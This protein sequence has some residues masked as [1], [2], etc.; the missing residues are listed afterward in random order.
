MPR[1]RVP[2]KVVRHSVTLD[3]QDHSEI[4]RLAAELDLSTAWI[5]RRAVSEF[6]GRHRDETE[7]ELPLGLSA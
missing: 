4:K 6:I 3:E 2:R 1:S 5:I 7:P